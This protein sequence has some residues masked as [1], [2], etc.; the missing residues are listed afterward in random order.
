MKI[1]LRVILLV[2]TCSLATSSR[3][4][5]TFHQGDPCERAHNLPACAPMV[6]CYSHRLVI[7]TDACDVTREGM[8]AWVHNVFDNATVAFFE[9][10]PLITTTSNTSLTV[11][12]SLQTV[13]G[14]DIPLVTIVTMLHLESLDWAQLHPGWCFTPYAEYIPTCVHIVTCSGQTLDLD[15]AAC[16]IYPA[17]ITAWLH[18]TFANTTNTTVEILDLSEKIVEV[19]LNLTATSSSTISL[20]SQIWA[21]RWWPVSGPHGLRAREVWEFTNASSETVVAILDSGLP[22]LATPIFANIADGYDFISDELMGKDGDGR[23]ASWEDPGDSSPECPGPSS[24]HGTQVA[25]VLAANMD[26]FRGVATNVTILPIRVL[27][28]CQTGHASDVA[29]AVV[30]ASGGLINNVTTNP[31]PATIISMSFSGVGQCPSYLQSAI[32]QAISNGCVLLAAAGNNGASSANYFPG[33]CGGVIVVQASTKSGTLASYSNNRGTLAAPGG[34]STN[35]MVTISPDANLESLVA[36]A[37]MGTSLSVPMVAGF[38]ALG[39]ELYG[40][41][42]NLGDTLTSFIDDCPM[43]LCGP[44]IVSFYGTARAIHVVENTNYKCSTNATKTNN[45]YQDTVMWLNTTDATWEEEHVVCDNSIV[46]ATNTYPCCAVTQ[47]ASG[48]LKSAVIL[49]DGSL[50]VWGTLNHGSAGT[51]VDNVVTTAPTNTVQFGTG[52]IIIS[53]AAGESHFCAVKQGGDVMCWGDN[54]NGQCGFSPTTSSSAPVPFAV[55]IGGVKA[56]AIVSGD[57]HTCIVTVDRLIV[58]CWGYHGSGQH[59]DGS[60]ISPAWKLSSN[61]LLPSVNSGNYIRQLNCKAYSCCIITSLE[62]MWCWGYNA[63]GLLGI[64]STTDTS[65]PTKLNLQ[66]N[67]VTKIAISVLNTC[68]VDS[69]GGVYCWGSNYYEQSGISGGGNTNTIYS[70]VFHSSRLVTTDAIDVESL[71]SVMIALKIDGTLWGWG[72]GFGSVP[73]NMNNWPTTSSSKFALHSGGGGLILNGDFSIP[74]MVPQTN[75]ASST[76]T[77]VYLGDFCGSVSLCPAGRTLAHATCSTSVR[78]IDCICNSGTYPTSATACAPI[79]SYDMPY[80]TSMALGYYSTC[81]CSASTGEIKCWGHGTASAGSMGYGDQIFRGRSTDTM[82]AA[83]PTVDLGLGSLAKV[84]V[85]GS[86]HVCAILFDNTV[87]CWGLNSHGQLGLGHTNNI[88][89][90][91]NEMGDNLPAVDLG[92]GRTAKQLSLSQLSSGYTCAILDDDSVKCWGDG[93]WGTLGT[94]VQEKRGDQPN[95]MGASLLAVDLG[96]GQYCIPNPI[97]LNRAMLTSHGIVSRRHFMF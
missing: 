35:P 14:A 73:Y 11:H 91:P 60:T 96:P 95:E 17:N 25:A 27:G 87:K 69:F 30:W 70:P 59:G 19:P 4:V 5:V 53:V 46:Q 97:Y 47:A 65:T 18:A 43:E 68:V 1:K 10:D 78:T 38:F 80:T 41:R 66:G 45:T 81:A 75:P 64:G 90:G 88:G 62:E 3:S 61:V 51:G 29:D 82:I 37:A 13:H 89:D 74:L 76:T 92:L 57:F 49:T 71:P 93:T 26:Q 94:G 12:G 16:S 77:P 55:D 23:D 33:N 22:P 44:G 40:P 9:E 85:S 31:V 21:D 6:K 7:N 86:K 50:K 42:F 39:L 34:D 52:V 79:V 63:Q 20:G 56:T 15:M 8:A 54:T 28:A 32:N 48:Y 84:V 83:L 24:W 36:V 2:I 58:K 72:Y 67:N